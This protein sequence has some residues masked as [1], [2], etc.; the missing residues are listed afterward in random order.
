MRKL[1]IITLICLC[2]SL[3]AQEFDESFLESLPEDVKKDVLERSVSQEDSSSKN[4]RSSQYSSKLSFEEDLLELKSRLEADLN[5]LENRLERDDEGLFINDELTLFGSDFFN[6]FQTSFMPINEP[7]PDSSYILD[8]GDVLRVQLIGQEDLMESLE[9][10]GDGSINLPEIGKLILVGL[11][12]NEATALV[13]SRVNSV[14][15]GTETYISLERIRDINILVT[16]NAKNVGVYTLNGNSNILQAITMAGGI[17]EYGSYREINLVRNE[18]IIETLDIYDLLIDGNYSV[19]KRLRSGDVIFVTPRKKVVTIDGAIKRPA[20]YELSDNDTLY[21]AIR[22]SNGIKHT[23]DYQNIY[24]ERILDAS[25]KSIPIRNVSQFKDIQPIDG[26][27]IYIRDIP[28]RTATINGAVLKPG[29]YTMAAG[30]TIFDLIEKSGGYTANAYPY[31]AVYENN[32]ARAINKKAKETLYI[33]FLDNIIRMSQQNIGTEFDL[34]PIL[35]LTT[36]I[37]NQKPNGRIVVDLLNE[38]S[39]NS[40]KIQNEDKIFIPE[41]TNNVYVYGEVS[42]EGSVMYAS[43]NNL[44]Y[45]IDKSGGYKKQADLKSIYVLHPNGETERFSN[46]R[47]IFES[48][49]MSA[50]NI[51]P[52][53]IIFIPKAIDESVSNRLA[54]QAY[55]SILGN[56]GIALASLSSINNN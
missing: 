1:N 47:N 17:N 53:S 38:D 19:R 40:L 26:D 30:E 9:I 43:G 18:K 7:N 39:M 52:G 45:F 49:P 4:Y 32:N 8:I 2:F 42:T 36:E 44:E 3:Q 13:K 5:E 23:A 50:P 11:T 14:F 16:G 48:E 34:T 6:T 55:V 33:E 24:L 15:I 25:L 27:L 21:S 56:L 29:S 46:K 35:G 37:K 10:V 28:Y 22:F 54:T 41:E 31:G 12:L 51:Y 20:K